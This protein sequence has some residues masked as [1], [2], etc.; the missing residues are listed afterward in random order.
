MIHLPKITKKVALPHVLW[1]VAWRNGFEKRELRERRWYRASVDARWTWIRGAS[2][3]DQTQLAE[4][5]G[6]DVA[7]ILPTKRE[8]AIDRSNDEMLRFYPDPLAK[9]SGSASWYVGCIG[10]SHG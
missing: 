8:K 1:P 9:S 2:D 4:Q 7:I 5:N 10:L 6:W 3:E